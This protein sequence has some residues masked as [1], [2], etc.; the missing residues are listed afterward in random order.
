[1]RDIYTIGDNQRRKLKKGEKTAALAIDRYDGPRIHQ[2]A[3][4]QYYDV[5]MIGYGGSND[6]YD[7][8]T[9]GRSRENYY[10]NNVLTNDVF[11][12]WPIKRNK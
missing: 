7:G 10:V 2:V 8:S 3:Q 1:M 5:R 12:D 6:I 4:S 9:L 11:R